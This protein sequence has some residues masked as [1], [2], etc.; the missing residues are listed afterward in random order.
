MI[1][2]D[3][4]PSQYA[5]KDGFKFHWYDGYIDAHF[6]RESWQL[7]KNGDE[8]NH[9][10]EDILDGEDFSKFGSVIIGEQ[11]KLF[12]NRGRNT[13][14]LKT[15][16]SVDGFEW[17]EQSHPAGDRAGQLSRMVGCHRWKS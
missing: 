11:G 3:F 7:V 1:T 17:P 9:P 14:I 12:F 6:D 15:S 4:G 13:W 16:A 8:Y 10:S 5:A 2:W